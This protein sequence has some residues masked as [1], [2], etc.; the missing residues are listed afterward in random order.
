MAKSPQ[1]NPARMP[2]KEDTAQHFGLTMRPVTEREEVIVQGP[3]M[4]P[5][6]ER[7]DGQSNKPLLA[8]KEE[9]SD[10]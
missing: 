5:V 8:P 10:T 6:T 2:D 1:E 4:R 7:E 3:T 9:P